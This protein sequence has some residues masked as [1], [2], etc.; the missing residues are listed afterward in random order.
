MTELKTELQN[1]IELKKGVKGYTWNVK[2]YFDDEDIAIK[3]LN[4]IDGI[5]RAMYN[6]EV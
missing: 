6:D 1:S 3:K 4:K 2:F 5:L